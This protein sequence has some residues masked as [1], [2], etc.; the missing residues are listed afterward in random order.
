[1]PSIKQI[2]LEIVTLAKDLG[3]RTKTDHF[4]AIVNFC[5][6]KVAIMLS[7]MGECESLTDFL[8]L[9]SNKANTKFIEIHSIDNLRNTANEYIQRREKAFANLENE[10]SGEVYGIT[11]RLQNPEDWENQHVSII[12]CRDYSKAARSYFTKWHEIAHLLTLTDQTRLIFRRTHASLNGGIPEERLMDVIAGKLGFYGGIFHK[13]I[14]NEISFE[15]I[16][17]LRLSLCN[18]ASKQASL[19][20]FVK[21]WSLPCIHLT[22]DMGLNKNEEAGL[23]QKTFDFVDAPEMTLRAI[24]VEPNDVA[25]KEKFLL[26]NNMRVPDNSVIQNVYKGDVEYAEAIE[27]LFWWNE[28]RGFP[29]KVKVRKIG[30]SVDALIIPYST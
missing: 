4:A 13:H 26:F 22:I 24:R 28:H 9:I 12:D 6:K 27:D 17:R 15:E 16:E 20:N 21:N 30:D 25:R 5:E 1:M 14:N 7:E 8:E 10:L 2:P 23:N 3:I 19:I 29:I 11:Y 18:E